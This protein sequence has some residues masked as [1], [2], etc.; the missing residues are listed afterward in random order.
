[1]Q[2]SN[3]SSEKKISRN[4]ESVKAFKNKQHKIKCLRKVYLRKSRKKI[5]PRPID[6]KRAEFVHNKQSEDEDDNEE[7]EKILLN[8]TL[9][10]KYSK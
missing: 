1:M 7:Q 9:V 5:L 8:V 3:S 4:V 2:L 6:R 10:E